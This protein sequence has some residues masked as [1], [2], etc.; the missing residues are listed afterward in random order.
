[1]QHTI[2]IDLIKENPQIFFKQ[3]D[4]EAEKEFINLLEYFIFKYDIRLDYSKGEKKSVV[5]SKNDFLDFIENH[6]IK[7]P[8]KFKFN[9]EEAN[10]R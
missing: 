4:K 5:N 7:L 6:K 9:R 3:L 10:E 2:D 1:M 8:E